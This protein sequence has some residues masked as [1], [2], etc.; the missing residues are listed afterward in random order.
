MIINQQGNSAAPTNMTYAAGYA[1][2]GG[3]YQCLDEKGWH[4]VLHCKTVIGDSIKSRAN[5]LPDLNACNKPVVF[6]VMD[7]RP[8]IKPY[9]ING[10]PVTADILSYSQLTYNLGGLEYMATKTDE[11]D[12]ACKPAGYESAVEEERMRALAEKYDQDVFCTLPSF[13]HAC[14]L[15]ADMD[16]MTVGTID[17]PVNLTNSLTNPPANTVYS[18]DYLEMGVDRIRNHRVKGAIHSILSYRLFTY[19]KKAETFRSAQLNGKGSSYMDSDSF[20]FCDEML[21]MA[22]GHNVHSHNCLGIVGMTSGANPKPIYQVVWF[23]EDYVDFKHGTV[24]RYKND[25]IGGTSTQIDWQVT[26]SGMAVSHKE[27][28]AVGYVTIS[29]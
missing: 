7:G 24:K 15:G 25:R 27:A 12:M 28:I 1:D 10:G 5:L 18:L 16:G 29:N 2:L 22:C 14:N 6:H 20:G 9:V 21:S 11:L 19:A 3:L 13:A 4:K 17:A 23:A 26:R 8:T